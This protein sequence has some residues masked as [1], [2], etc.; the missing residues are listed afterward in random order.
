MVQVISSH[1]MS[2]VESITELQTK[3]AHLER[4]I[5]DQDAEFYRMAQ[6][7]DSLSKMVQLQ[8]G[9]INALSAGGSSGA[10][11]MPADEKPPHY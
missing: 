1:I 3:L 9:Q 4:H 10:D 2:D 8:K 5:N 11:E 7:V 6:R